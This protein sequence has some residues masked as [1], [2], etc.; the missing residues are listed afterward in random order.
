MCGSVGAL[1]SGHLVKVDGDRPLSPRP[2]QLRRLASYVFS[3]STLETEEY[4]HSSIIQRSRSAE[5][6]PAHANQRLRPGMPRPHSAMLRPQRHQ[7]L[8]PRAHIQH[9]LAKLMHKN[10]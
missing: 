8:S 9:I 2:N 1:G 6:S 5:S 7:T 4:P 3:S 10:S